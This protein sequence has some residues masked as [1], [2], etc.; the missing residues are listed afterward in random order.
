[1]GVLGDLT[2]F[3]AVVQALLRQFHFGVTSGAGDEHAL[4]PYDGRR[5]A[6]S[7]NRNVPG[8]IF[9]RA[10]ALGQVGVVGHAEGARATELGPVGEGGGVGVPGDHE[11]N[12]AQNAGVHG[13][14][15]WNFEIQKSN[16]E[17]GTTGDERGAKPTKRFPFPCVPCVPWLP[18]LW[19]GL[20]RAGR[21]V[22]LL[23]SH[24]VICRLWD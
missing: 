22:V 4:A 21:S 16:V 15:C 17:W 5:P 11:R 8:D 14:E 18:W 12:D 3:T 6:A 1:M 9:V 10:P 23:S 19:L 24:R 20:C 13:T 7:G 2:T